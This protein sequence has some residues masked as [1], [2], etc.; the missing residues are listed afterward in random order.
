MD[1]LTSLWKKFVKFVR[2]VINVSGVNL[3]TKKSADEW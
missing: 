3:I 1:L 2:A